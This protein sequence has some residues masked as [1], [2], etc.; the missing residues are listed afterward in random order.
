M[1]EFKIASVKQVPKQG[2]CTA[3]FSERLGVTTKSL[4][5]WRDRYGK[6]A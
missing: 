2:Y 6:H 5:S 4:Y 3:D 1:E